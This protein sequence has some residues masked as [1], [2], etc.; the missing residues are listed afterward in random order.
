MLFFF[1]RVGQR[2]QRALVSLSDL[3]WAHVDLM[4]DRRKRL[5]LDVPQRKDADIDLIQRKARDQRTAAVDGADV[6]NEVLALNVSSRHIPSRSLIVGRLFSL[7]DDRYGG[8]LI[9]QPL[10]VDIIHRRRNGTD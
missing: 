4:R 10:C 3:R 2:L 9:D 1:R 7:N 5:V 6:L 8:C